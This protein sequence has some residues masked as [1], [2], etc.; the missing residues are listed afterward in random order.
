M[1][2]T[3]L[4]KVLYTCLAEKKLDLPDTIVDLKGRVVIITGANIGLGLESAK[5]FYAMNPARLILAVRSINKGEAAK[6]EIMQASQGQSYTSL[7]VWELDL[8][9]FQSVKNFGR[10]CET[11]LERLDILLENGGILSGKWSVTNDGWEAG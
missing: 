2:A 4:L 8:A 10:R 3:A 7:E 1:S 6:Q 9:S 11:E 5:R